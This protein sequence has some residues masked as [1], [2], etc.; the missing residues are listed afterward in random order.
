MK[1]LSGRRGSVLLYSISAG[2]IFT[3]LL[4]GLT[5]TRMGMASEP[6]LLPGLAISGLL[7]RSQDYLPVMT[8][9]ALIYSALAY[10]AFSLIHRR[11]HPK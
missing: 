5:Y 3:G 4:W 11:N 6:A 1:T 7:F 2:M 10:A 8:A 9:T